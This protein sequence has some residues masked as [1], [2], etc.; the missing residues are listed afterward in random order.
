[1]V[2]QELVHDR[3]ELVGGHP[4]SDRAPAAAIA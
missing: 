1:M 2:E 4:G 3:V